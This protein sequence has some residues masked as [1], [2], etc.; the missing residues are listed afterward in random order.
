MLNLT[1]DAGNGCRTCS[2]V[3]LLKGQEAGVFIHQTTFLCWLSV[4]LGPLAPPS[5]P[6]L[7]HLLG[8]LSV[9]ST[10]V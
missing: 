6:R 2:S 5:A 8:L 3:V 1:G 7:G 4:L 10:P 9:S